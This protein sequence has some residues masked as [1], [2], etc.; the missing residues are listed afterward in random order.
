[1]KVKCGEN[2]RRGYQTTLRAT[3]AT[4][5]VG[6][7]VFALLKLAFRVYIGKDTVRSSPRHAK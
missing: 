2:L 7:D 5:I 1:M 4:L 3:P 6:T